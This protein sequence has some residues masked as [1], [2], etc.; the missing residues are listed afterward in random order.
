M[1]NLSCENA[2]SF[3]GLFPLKLGGAGKDSDIGWSCDHQTPEN[4]GFNNLQ[5]DKDVK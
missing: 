4:S 3:P 1:R 2:T 5:Y